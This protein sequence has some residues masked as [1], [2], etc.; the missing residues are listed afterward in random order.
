MCDLQKITDDFFS[1]VKLFRLYQFTIDF[2][3]DCEYELN[4][5]L[6]WH[7]NECPYDKRLSR[8][9]SILEAQSYTAK[10]ILEIMKEDLYDCEELKKFI[11]FV[12]AIKKKY[13]QLTTW[14]EVDFT[15]AAKQIKRMVDDEILKEVY[16][17]AK[18]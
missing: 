1:S 10:C 15:E 18:E 6:L 17:N 14:K 9:C 16:G 7:L 5:N 13:D 4:H 2:F 12:D 3:E 8:F 11:L